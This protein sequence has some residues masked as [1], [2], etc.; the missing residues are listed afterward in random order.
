MSECCD[1][2]KKCSVQ[3]GVSAGFNSQSIADGNTSTSIRIMQMDCPT[4]EGLIRDIFVSIPAVKNVE[5]NLIQRVL[6]VVHEPDSLDVI[7]E[8]IRSLGYQPEVMDAQSKSTVMPMHATKLWWSLA[9]AG[10]A[11]LAAEVLSWLGY[12]EWLTAALAI[13]S[14]ASSGLTTYKKGWVALRSGILNINALMSIAVTG[15]LILGEWPEAAMV[16]VLF[17][18]AELIE[19]M[20]LDKARQAISSLMKLAPEKVTVRQR[21]GTWL[22]VEVSRIVIGDVVRVKPG[23]RIGI[24]G[25]I[26]LGQSTVNQAPITGESLPIEKTVGDK[27]FAGTINQ[28]GSFEFKV[29]ALASN[30]TL[31]RIIHA[32][33]TAQGAKAPTQRFVDQFARI[34]TPIIFAVAIMI[35][36]SPPLL[37]GGG[38]HDWVYKA[39][40]LLVIACPCALVISTPVTIVSGLAAAAHQ[41]ILIKGG[42]YLEKGYKL[43]WLALDKTGTITNGKPVQTD[44]EVLSDLD[45]DHC[46][47]LA[48]SLAGRSDH[49]VSQ[50]VAIAANNDNVKHESVQNFEAITGRGVRGVIADNLTGWVIIGWLRRGVVALMNLKNALNLWSGK[51]KR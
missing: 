13:V 10:L 4:E 38:W 31:A 48:A 51:E 9:L 45:A 30:T 27:V 42:I 11:A 1:D 32:V 41:G 5:F 37:L 40:V 22:E 43:K 46:R 7:L 29:L 34:Y 44:F 35:A 18:V 16:M 6:T 21:D 36:V 26:V 19:K 24:D 33:E 2:E 49:P 28:S 50:A 25:E 20:A 15:A 39:L 3:S 14:I 17:A 12:S 8:A 23:E 47:R